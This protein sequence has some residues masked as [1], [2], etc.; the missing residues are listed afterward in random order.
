[1][2]RFSR[3]V[4]VLFTLLAV[5]LVLAIL[6]G[7]YLVYRARRE[8]DQTAARDA[9]ARAR[10]VEAKLEA[11]A[12]SAR[13]A[14]D[15]KKGKSAIGDAEAFLGD[16]RFQESLQASEDAMAHL[17]PVEGYLDTPRESAKVE[18]ASGA[19]TRGT[20]EAVA[21]GASLEAGETLAVPSAGRALVVFPSRESVLLEGG[22][23]FQLSS[24]S[25]G[26][27]QRCVECEILSGSL[28]YHCPP[29]L[30]EQASGSVKAGAAIVRPEPGSM[31][32]IGRD[33]A[34]GIV[35]AREGRCRIEEE[36]E[37]RS[38]R[39]GLDGETLRL[40]GPGSEAKRGGEVPP[41]V[42][43]PIDG[44]VFWAAPGRPR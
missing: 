24:L 15:L 16:G 20:G 5:L 29:V 35:E 41:L 9:L 11:D 42:R 39:A 32:F 14:D 1:M 12:R 3:I 37:V 31:I 22:T 34:R 28:V 40:G 44:R 25:G 18:A 2:T 10:Q 23:R 4:N 27:S 6:G 26:P 17:R 33:G 8:A 7:V 21:A 43:E 19:V 38:L 13:F 30:P 36:G